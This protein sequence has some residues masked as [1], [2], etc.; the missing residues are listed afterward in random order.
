MPKLSKNAIREAHDQ[1][2]VET[3]Q[4]T[5]SP[6]QAMIAAEPA[7]ADKKAYA[8]VKANRMLK[9]SDV[10]ERIQK[11][12]ETMYN[13][14]LKTIKSAINSDNEQIAVNTSFRVIEHLRGTPVKR[15]LNVTA[16]ANIED[17]LFD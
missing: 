15:N 6:L 8:A 2:F 4:E 17:A 7:L 10:Q 12:L 16:T 11:K 5:N 3:L 13:P 14:A 1:R 9:R